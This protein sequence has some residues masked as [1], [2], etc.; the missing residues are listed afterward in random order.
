MLDQRII[1]QII[2]GNNI[3]SVI[4]QYLPLKKTGANFK[5][6]CPFHDEKTP[7]FVV[8]DKKQIF[9]CF[10]CGK[11]GNVI[12]FVKEIENI[13]F[14]EA[15]QKLAAKAGIKLKQPAASLTKQR[16]RQELLLKVYELAKDHYCDNLQRFGDVAV[17]QLIDRGI[18]KA[19]V[20]KFEIGYALNSSSGLY[21]YLLKCEINSKLLENSGLFIKTQKGIVDLFRERIIFPIHSANGN[22]VAFGARIV[23]PDQQGGKYINS[24]TTELYTKGKELY[25]FH[26]TRNEIRKLDHALVTE[27]YTDFLRLYE[28][29][30]HNSVATLGT[31]FTDEQI[32]ALSRYS[33]N[34]YLLY[35]GDLAG[36]RAAIKAAENILVAGGNPKIVSLPDGEDADSF[37]KKNSREDLQ[38]LISN[39]SPLV[40]YVF[41]NSDLGLDVKEKLGLLIEVAN[42]FTDLLNRELLI[43]EIARVFNISQSSLTQRIRQRRTISRQKQQETGRSRLSLSRQFMEEKFFLIFLINGLIE[44]IEAIEGI[45]SG[46]FF[47][48]N[49]K[50]VFETWQS[51]DYIIDN[52]RIASILADLEEKDAMQVK[53]IS[54]LSLADVP[55]I[56]FQSVINDL[57]IRKYQNELRKIDDNLTPDQESVSSIDKKKVLVEKLRNSSRKVTNK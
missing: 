34:I 47:N 13:S 56:P 14:F 42:H 3:V 6:C 21:N 45:D 54:E 17:Q 26:L 29:G 10:G 36:K 52:E 49:Y 35:D 44:D 23:Y 8:S 22:I 43:K 5:A 33:K 11:G 28:N 57:K 4:E 37:L 12:H 46:F 38:Y 50:K 55:P 16:S 2:E 48:E 39:A 30:F 7:S 15:M 18:S 1:D 32:K 31:A 20:D 41:R 9:K 40:E 27:G 19:T 53:I 25:G 24:P 51:F